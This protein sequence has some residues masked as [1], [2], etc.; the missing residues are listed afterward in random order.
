MM[1]TVLSWSS[2]VLLYVD[3]V[4]SHGAKVYEVCMGPRHRKIQYNWFERANS[5]D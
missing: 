3:S 5:S 1:D 4:G 2:G